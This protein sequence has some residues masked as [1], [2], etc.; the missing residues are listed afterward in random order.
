M[1]PIGFHSLLFLSHCNQSGLGGSIKACVFALCVLGCLWEGPVN[2][3][4]NVKF[5]L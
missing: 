4:V 1:L 2:P 5:H 3:P